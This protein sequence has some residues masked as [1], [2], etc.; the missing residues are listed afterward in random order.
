MSEEALASVRRAVQALPAYRFTATPAGIKLDQNESPEDLPPAIRRRALERLEAAAW[1]RYPDLH[2][3]ALAARLG[4]RHGWPADGVVVA[5]GSNVLIQALTIL[6]GIGERSIG[7]SP[8]FSVYELQA[9]LLG[10]PWSEVPLQRDF[11]IPTERLRAETASGGGVLFLPVPLAPTGNAVA[12]ADV[13]AIAAGAAPG[14]TVVI[15]EAYAEFAEVD[16]D[17]IAR[18]HPRMVRLRTLSKAFALAGARV[19][20]ALAHPAFARELRKVLLPFSVSTL[21]VEVATAAL[22]AQE[23]LRERAAAI[24]AERERVQEALRGRGVRSIDSAANFVLMLVPDPEALHRGLLT[25]GVVV[26]R[27]DHLPGLRGGVRVSIGTPAE[28][29]AFLAGLFRLPER[30][31]RDE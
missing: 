16:H 20:Y 5:G 14:F 26:R 15:D 9:R 8:T 30:V 25:A 17:A 31:W 28:N 7:V 10:V 22:E 11:S 2:A 24:V 19:G 4:E 6:S 12:S 3:D 29:D 1:N 27:Q 23:V 18:A 13:E 21:Q